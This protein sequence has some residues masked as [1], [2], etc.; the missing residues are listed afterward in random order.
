MA[1]IEFGILYF[2]QSLHT[3]WL[4][5][6]MKEITSLGDHGIF[7]IAAG[8]V[9][10]C[11]KKT[12]FIGLCIL[13]SLAAGLLIGNMVLKN[14]IARERPCWIDDSIPLLIRNPKDYSFPSGHTLASFEGAVSIWLYNRKWGAAA[15]ILAALISVSRMYLFVHFPTDVLGGMIL[16]ILIAVFVHS[17][18]ENIRISKKNTCF[19][20]D[21]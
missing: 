8:V 21:L 20:V 9:L 1:G 18:V 14:M 4:D 2:L 5:V 12:R 19:P 7:W 10:L 13:F 3:S 17:T 16:G 6:F 11:F 15:L